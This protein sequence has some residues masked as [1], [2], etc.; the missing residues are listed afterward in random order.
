MNQEEMLRK[1]KL[2]LFDM[3]G[4]LYLGSQ[5]H[6]L[7][8]ELLETIK[9]TGRK[10]LF[11]TNNSSKNVEDYIKKLPARLFWLWRNTVTRRMGPPWWA[12]GSTLM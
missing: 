2:F 9:A 1:T 4:I 6:D 11:M 12:T 8:M 5:R 7:T 3:D 10:Y